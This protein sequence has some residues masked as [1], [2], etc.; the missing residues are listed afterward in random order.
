MIWVAWRQFRTQALVTLGLFAAFTVLVLVTG[1]HLRDIYSSLGGAHCTA[2]SDCTG[3]PTHGKVLA[4]LLGPALLAIPALLGMFW[5]APLVARELESGTHR[6]AW[7]QSV[8]RRRWLSVRVALVAVAGIA[9]AG[10][11]SWLVSW[12]FAPLDAV[13][14]N[15]FDPGVFTERGVVAV[16]YA[17][18]ALAL[19]VAAGALMRRTLPAMAATLL[20]FAGARVAVTFLVRPNLLSATRVLVPVTFGNGVGFVSSASGVSIAPNSSRIPNAWMISAALVDRAHHA[21]SAA[22]LHDLLVRACPAIATGL[23]QPAGGA[24]KGPKGP[25]GGAV[26][27]CEQ[28]LSQHLQQLVTYQPPGHYWTLQALETAIFFA[29]ALT[30]IGATVW[31][32]GRRATHRPAAG[33]P[34]ERTA[35]PPALEVAPDIGMP[36]APHAGRPPRR[37]QRRWLWLTAAPLTACLAAACASTAES[38]NATAPVNCAPPGVKL[39]P[40]YSPQAYRVAYG[41]APLLSRGIDGSGETVVMPELASSPPATDIRRDMAA[42]DRQFGL[43]P[44]KLR[45]VSTITRS[46]TPY[47]ADEEEVQDTEMAHAIAPGATLDVVLVPQDATSSRASFT[48][49]ATK[50]VQVSVALHAAVIS[51][52]GSEGEHLFTGAEMAQMNAAMKQA[53]DHHVTV[54]ASSG[55]LG[56]I[57][58]DGPPVQVSMP[59]SDPL[60]LAV[61]GTILDATSPGGNYRG[62]MAWN[63]GTDASN[64]G[65]SRVFARPSYQDGI[66]RIGATRGVP[67]VAA[68]ADSATAMALE[69]SNGELRPATGTSASTPLWAGVIALADQQ[70]GRRLGLVNPAIYA[71]A[72]GRAYHRAF[73]DVVTGD[74]SVLWP[75][76]VFTGY[77]ASPGWDPVTG[78]GSPD[79][80]YLVPLLAGAVRSERREKARGLS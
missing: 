22:R 31:R 53:S 40:C 54:V 39:P 67:D 26:L 38:V 21:L 17:A 66:A 80:Q 27:A 6:L 61:G 48:A 62:E 11:S 36:P 79:A 72:R 35:R 3:L 19:G 4:D 52:S 60:V 1:L 71:I 74:N 73:H 69:Y 56:A 12:W 65:Y 32:V 77:N 46:A 42:F 2:R 5:G 7:T 64:G 58:D 16:G 34:R 63:D 50:V 18:F 76:R 70:A 68:N 25:A 33:E 10:L 55:D 43:S 8:T 59:A 41:V 23:P 75:T 44:A 30:L 20:G 9:V 29:G 37:R 24:P 57:S 51:I 49:A 78:C 14:L 45:V 15:R 28:R 47:L 13:N